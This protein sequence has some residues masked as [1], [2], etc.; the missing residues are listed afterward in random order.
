MRT[1]L[2]EKLQGW[3]GDLNPF[4]EFG[5]AI[6][7]L[8]TVDRLSR[9]A[10][11]FGNDIYVAIEQ[12][13]E[14]FADRQSDNGEEAKSRRGPKARRTITSKP[15]RWVPSAAPEKPEKIA[16]AEVQHTADEPQQDESDAEDTSEITETS[17][18]DED[19]VEA[20]SE[21]EN[22]SDG[23]A[24]SPSKICRKLPILPKKAPS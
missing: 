9:D 20:K 6:S 4:I 7:K 12:R 21:I 3:Q 24:E 22:Q 15:I 16:E 2:F 10:V 1:Q 11:K 19:T 13:R 17:A 14:L 18:P 23:S 8:E 5:Q